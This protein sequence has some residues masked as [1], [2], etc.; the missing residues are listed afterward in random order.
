[1]NTNLEPT[2]KL[3]T[4]RHC[5]GCYI[6]TYRGRTFRA[7]TM[8]H[9]SEGLAPKSDTTWVLYEETDP[10]ESDGYWNHFAGLWACKEAIIEG[11]DAEETA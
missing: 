5:T 1:M 4:R 3:K 2:M 9:H 10:D 7:S 11:C 8:A 6:I